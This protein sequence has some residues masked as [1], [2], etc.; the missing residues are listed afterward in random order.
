MG[1]MDLAAIKKLGSNAEVKQAKPL[2]VKKVEPK[3][4]E[5]EDNEKVIIDDNKNKLSEEEK[6]DMEAEI[7]RLDKSLLIEKNTEEKPKKPFKNKRKIPYQTISLA[8]KYDEY[9][10]FYDYLDMEEINPSQF[11]RLMLKE[12]GVL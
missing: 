2:E 4:P 6:S 7:K 9:S 11:V 5:I 12:K 1:R 10:A 3:I 8:L